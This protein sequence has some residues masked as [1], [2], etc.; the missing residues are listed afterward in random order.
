MVELCCFFDVVFGNMLFCFCF[1][2]KLLIFFL[3]LF[4]VCFSRL[5]LKLLFDGVLFDLVCLEN[6]GMLFIICLLKFVN[7]F[8]K[9]VL[10]V[11][12]LLF[13]LDLVFLRFLLVRL[14]VLGL[15]LFIWVFVCFFVSV[16]VWLS[17]LSFFRIVLVRFFLVLLVLLV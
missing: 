14:F 10:F 4:R 15:V 12:V 17:L 7:V 2:L 9:V 1:S 16:L 3:K 5:L 8:L 13:M 6:D 11:S